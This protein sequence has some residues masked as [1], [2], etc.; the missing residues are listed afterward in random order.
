MPV[1]F[2]G[3]MNRLKFLPLPF[4]AKR[5]RPPNPYRH[6]LT[7]F[8]VCPCLPR[9]WSINSAGPGPVGRSGLTAMGN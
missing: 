6:L 4:D 3:Y 9:P 8:M 7:I 5:Y 1:S 2:I